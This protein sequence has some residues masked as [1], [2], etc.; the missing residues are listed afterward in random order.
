MRHIERFGNHNPILGPGFELPSGDKMLRIG[1]NGFIADVA[2]PDD[3]RR[4][5][6]CGKRWSR[7]LLAGSELGPIS[8]R[9]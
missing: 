3:F 9:G 8:Q 6:I 1:L 2:M 7:E 4:A 5:G